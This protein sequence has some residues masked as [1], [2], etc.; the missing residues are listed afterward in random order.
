M[1]AT[2]DVSWL[3]GG[4]PGPQDCPACSS[5]TASP[6][7]TLRKGKRWGAEGRACKLVGPQPVQRPRGG[8]GRCV[9][10]SRLVCHL[11]G[12]EETRRGF[13]VGPT[14]VGPGCQAS[15]VAVCPVG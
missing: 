6:K 9:C 5:H 8:K 2:Q 11:E 13:W 1:T 12:S 15:H 3:W 10:L 14:R 4:E 7:P